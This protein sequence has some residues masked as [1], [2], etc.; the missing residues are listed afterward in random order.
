MRINTASKGIATT[1]MMDTA[2]MVAI[3]TMILGTTMVETIG[4]AQQ[5]GSHSVPGS[6]MDTVLGTGGIVG[7]WVGGTDASETLYG[8]DLADDLYGLGGNDTI[9]GGLG[10][11]HLY[12]G[13]GHDSL[14][15]GAGADLL[16]GGEG[17]DTANY[18]GGAHGVRVDLVAGTG[19]HGAAEGD[20]YL[21]IENV[22]GTS[23]ADIIIGNSADNVLNGGD[24]NDQIV[25]GVGRDLII[26]GNGYD[27]L[28]GD[29]TGI[30][31]ADT[32]VFT[33]FSGGAYITDF[34][35]GLD[36]IQLSGFSP[37]ALGADG[38]LA[39]GNGQTSHGLSMDD[40]LYYNTE[41]HTLY[42]IDTR[43]GADGPR[44][45]YVAEIA[46]VGDDVHRLTTDDLFFL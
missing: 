2:D 5:F 13:T 45:F 34:Q 36:K 21:S 46:T 15:G 18:F 38:G 27:T 19:F 28:T 29:T 6:V 33:A 22:M 10:N 39:W 8:T 23:F 37:E 3:D 31:M 9:F 35:K 4:I 24:G 41:T 43:S 25:G 1:A 44:I 14:T 40:T 42:Q 7:A 17:T 26:G 30:M 11:D 20:T 12:G 32:F 16:D